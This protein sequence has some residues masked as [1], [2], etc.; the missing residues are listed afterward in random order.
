MLDAPRADNEDSRLAALDALCLLDTPPEPRF[1]RLTRIAAASLRV[2]YAAVSLIDRDRQWFKS[3]H[4]LQVAETPRRVSFCGHVVVH[5]DPVIITDARKDARFADNPLVLG[6]PHVRFY[7]GVPLAAPDGSHVGTLCVFDPNPRQLSADERQLLVDLAEVVRSELSAA[8]FS[9]DAEQSRRLA[10]AFRRHKEA[11]DAANREKSRFLAQMSHELRTPLNGLLGMLT[12][13]SD[14][15]LTAGQARMLSTAR[16]AGTLLTGLVEDSLDLSTL[17]TGRVPLSRE[18]FRVSEIIDFLDRLVRPMAQRKGLAFQVHVGSE[19]PATM[20][21]DRRRLQQILINL[22]GNAIKFTDQGNVRLGVTTEEGGVRVIWN[23]SDTGPGIPASHVDRLFRPFAPADTPGD[24]TRRGTGLG[25]AIAHGLA[26]AMGGSVALVDHEQPGCVMRVALP[27]EVPERAHR[28]TDALP[29]AVATIAPLRVLLVEDDPI[30]QTVAR[31]LL[32]R[33]GHV[34]LV[35]GTVTDAV[36]ALCAQVFDLVLLDMDL[37]D[38]TGQ[39]V[40]TATVAN[41]GPP[42]IAVSAHSLAPEQLCGVAG[43]LQGSLRKPLERRALRSELARVAGTSPGSAPAPVAV[44]VDLDAVLERVNGDQAL[45]RSL[46]DVLESRLPTVLARLE[47]AASGNDAGT[48]ASLLHGLRGQ[49]VNLGMNAS[50]SLCA[51]LEA[52]VRNALPDD[53]ATR[54][55]AL[56]DI[57]RRELARLRALI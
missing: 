13:L 48:L 5:G 1:D 37:P 42:C 52:T 41:G 2:E 3:I 6:P 51:G 45:V 29:G 15:N 19:L 21:G 23:V 53:L 32:E 36:A 35:A 49:S 50:A 54:L 28:V 56:H 20:V 25:L 7:A 4:G 8:W 22:L 12:L 24:Q 18:S 57:L 47:E 9:H 55:D 44:Q 14:T 39:D 34:V 11:A 38:G 17:G 31:G 46:L 33:D 43:G 16:E 26:E 10:A 30:S 40:A 27:R